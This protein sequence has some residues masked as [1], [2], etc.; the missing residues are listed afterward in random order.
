MNT[1]EQDL[2]ALGDTGAKVV[3]SLRK[4]GIM[5]R[6]QQPCEC[7]IAIYLQRQGHT[8][9]GVSSEEIV[10]EDGT[11]ETPIGASEFIFWFDRGEYPSLEVSLPLRR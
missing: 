8:I 4:L 1:I 11:I 9:V 3:A 10:S 2:A 7:P 5:G 6:R